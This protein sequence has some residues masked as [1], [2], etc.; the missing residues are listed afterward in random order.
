[1]DLLLE[2][3]ININQLTFKYQA[4]IT[5]QFELRDETILVQAMRY[6]DTNLVKS[7]I[8]K[9]ANV[10]LKNSKGQTAIMLFNTY[11]DNLDILKLLL[12][13]GAETNIKDNECDHLVDYIVH[14]SSNVIL[15]LVEKFNINPLLEA[16]V[17]S[18][19]K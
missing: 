14:W 2:K 6:R 16:I 13:N 4:G 12:D 18:K 17:N 1:L 7:I 8:D 3:K 19:R 9:G 15:L 10:N 11:T 5:T